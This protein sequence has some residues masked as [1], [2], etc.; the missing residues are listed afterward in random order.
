M[1]FYGTKILAP[2]NATKG[3]NDIA[4]Y[5]LLP[6]D[7]YKPSSYE[8]GHLLASIPSSRNLPPGGNVY[9]TIW[10]I[11]PK[12]CPRSKYKAEPCA[13]TIKFYINSQA[14]CNVW[15]TYGLGMNVT[16]YAMYA[17]GSIKNQNGNAFIN[18][19]F[20]DFHIGVNTFSYTLGDTYEYTSYLDRFA[21]AISL[22]HNGGTGTYPY[23]NPAN[24]YF[25]IIL[26]NYDNTENGTLYV[27]QINLINKKTVFIS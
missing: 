3:P 22:S 27:N 12:G 26:G 1:I 11:T 5:Y 18:E 20:F 24:N 10:W 16:T 4:W 2:E 13:A 23:A 15:N 17:D 14:A 9:Y 25:D 21:L 6:T 19:G 8:E 7:S